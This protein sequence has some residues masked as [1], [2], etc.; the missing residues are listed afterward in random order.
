MQTYLQVLLIGIGPSQEGIQQAFL[1]GIPFPD[2]RPLETHAFLGLGG[3]LMASGVEDGAAPEVSPVL[4]ELND[5][6]GQLLL[7]RPPPDEFP[8]IQ[9]QMTDGN[10]EEDGV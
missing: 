7:E 10:P 6:L 2:R 5:G 8:R 3:S 4:H 9:G 1:N